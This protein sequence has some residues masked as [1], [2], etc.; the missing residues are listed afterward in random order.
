[1]SSFIC[2]TLVVSWPMNRIPARFPLPVTN[3]S[4]CV[5]AAIDSA[6]VA[7]RKWFELDSCEARGD[8]GVSGTSSQ[9]QEQKSPDQTDQVEC[10]AD[11]EV[12]PDV[13]VEVVS[14]VPVVLDLKLCAPRDLLPASEVL[15][16][17]HR[18]SLDSRHA[19]LAV[20]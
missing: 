14:L 2:V 5:G 13:G 9:G 3:N 17:A 11:G 6:R 19:V 8:E 1:M 12:I 4:R 7:S 10:D 15:L 20:L 16:C 18:S